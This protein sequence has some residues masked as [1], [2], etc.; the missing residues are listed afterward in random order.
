M[1]CKSHAKGALKLFVTET[2]G[3]KVHNKMFAGINVNNT[4]PFAPSTQPLL[5]K[6]EKPL[7]VELFKCEHG[8]QEKY[9]QLY[10]L[11]AHGK[12]A[13]IVEMGAG[14]VHGLQ[15]EDCAEK[16][17]QKKEQ[18]FLSRK[19][20]NATSLRTV[21]P[22]LV[23]EK[24]QGLQGLGLVSSSNDALSYSRYSAGNKT[25]WMMLDERK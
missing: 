5:A 16:L 4:G 11:R 7:H 14:I 2:V 19:S 13:T 1:E 18:W 20:P 15:L 12:C 23:F 21:M 9:S 22:E 25:L 6:S 24:V 8:P 10:Q 17:E 3:N